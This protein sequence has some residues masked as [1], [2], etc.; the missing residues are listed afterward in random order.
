MRE[1]RHVAKVI[2][3]VLKPM[4]TALRTKDSVWVLCSIPKPLQHFRKNTGLSEIWSTLKSRN[5][6]NCRKFNEIN[7]FSLKSV[8]AVAH[9]VK[10]TNPCMEISSPVPAA[11]MGSSHGPLTCAACLPPLPQPYFLSKYC[12]IKA[13][14]AKKSFKRKEI[15][16]NLLQNLKHTGL[17]VL[18][19]NRNGIL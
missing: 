18:T 7:T 9:G 11:V 2:W 3:L 8:A 14:R 15:F 6:T 12:E 1:R 5:H 16:I 13:T 19:T 10:P 17:R 4:T